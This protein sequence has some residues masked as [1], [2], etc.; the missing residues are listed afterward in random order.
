MQGMRS[1][2]HRN[3]SEWCPRHRA[4]QPQ[5]M[6]AAATAAVRQELEG[7]EVAAVIP[8]HNEAAPP[9]PAPSLSA[10]EPSTPAEAGP[11]PEVAAPLPPEPAPPSDT[12]D[13]GQPMPPADAPHA[14]TSSAEDASLAV[15]RRVSGGTAGVG[16]SG[17]P[18]E[19][20]SGSA[21]ASVAAGDAVAVSAASVPEEGEILART[22][23]SASGASSSSAAAGAAGPDDVVD[24]ETDASPPQTPDMSQPDPKASAAEAPP[25]PPHESSAAATS[26]AAAPSPAARHTAAPHTQVR[27]YHVTALHL[28]ACRAAGANALQA[29]LK[30]SAC[31]EQR[32]VVNTCIDRA[33]NGVGQVDDCF[34]ETTRLHPCSRCQHGQCQ[35]GAP[36]RCP[37]HG[38]STTRP[39][40][41]RCTS[42]LTAYTPPPSLPA[43]RP[44]RTCMCTR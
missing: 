35:S 22:P 40:L 28:C 18:D 39:P 24:M 23:Q 34:I 8:P 3:A 29:M 13:E 44:P 16:T 27:D 1:R 19:P 2:L 6:Q 20:R 31:D 9:L 4:H 14:M 33:E 7:G 15:A 17:R 12:A 32:H 43:G 36:W 37:S 11:L 10:A 38:A 25:A 21:S 30:C 42:A 41:G 26:T 5:S